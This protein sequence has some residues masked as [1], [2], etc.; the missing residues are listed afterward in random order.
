MWIATVAN[1]AL[2]LSHLMPRSINIKKFLRSNISKGSDNLRRST[3]RLI[4]A[5]LCCAFA[6]A[7]LIFAKESNV[8]I[9]QTTTTTSASRAESLLERAIKRSAESSG[10]IVG[11]SA[12]RIESGQRV[13]LN[14]GIRFP[15]A[16]VYK[17]PIALQL[18]RKVDRGELRLSDPITLSE[19]SFR[20]GHSPI[21]DFANNKPLTLTLERLLEL[22]LGESD[23]SASDTLLRLAGG[24]S[25]VTARMRDLGIKGIEV[26]R[27]EGQLI[28]NHRGV[29]E[30]PPESEWTMTLLDGLSAKVAPGEREA[31]ALAYADDPRDTSTPDAMADLLVR[32]H[33]RDVLEPTS[34]ERLLQIMTATQTGP[35]RLKGLLPNGTVVAHK[36]GTMGGTTNDVGIVTLPDGGG[37]LAIAIFI[38]ASSKD[39]PERERVI[40]EIARTVYDFFVLN[41]ENRS[42]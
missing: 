2:P 3:L 29:R 8:A 21:R 12:I 23:N 33:R 41:G 6:L 9:A 30:L 24:P 39:V 36:T 16:S 17:L 38:K 34:M 7:S 20:P 31:A 4:I 27:P 13:S 19:N 18:L 25:A 42:Q 15:M 35:L 11:V 26:N 28:L 40:A 1:V 22:M 10:G 14:G 5:A 37:H 32:V